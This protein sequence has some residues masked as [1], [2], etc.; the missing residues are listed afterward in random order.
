MPADRRRRRAGA[1]RRHGCVAQDNAA[2]GTNAVGALARDFQLPGSRRIVAQPPPTSRRWCR[3]RRPRSPAGRSR[4]SK[5]VPP[6]RVR[7]RRRRACR[8][9]RRSRNSS[10]KA[11]RPRRSGARPR[12]RA[13]AF[14][15]CDRAR[16]GAHQAPAAVPPAPQAPRTG[17]WIYVLPALA[18]LLVVGFAPARRRRRVSRSR[19]PSRRRRSQAAPAQAGA[20]A[21]PWLGWAQGREGATDQHRG[22]GQFELE[23]TPA[24]AG[25]EHPDRRQDVQRRPDTGTG[26][27]CLLPLGRSRKHQMPSAGHRP[28]T[29]G[30]IRGS[31]TMPRDEMKALFS[32]TAICSCR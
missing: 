21:R 16:R 4:P 6:R 22:G 30:V 19:R 31:V 29:T 8:R 7:R 11:S 3:S 26:D 18:G 12:R 9:P 23:T 25:P 15:P 32:R 13:T 28:D 1:V 24:G 14:Q 5:P 2:A 20:V 27:R 10:P 17:S